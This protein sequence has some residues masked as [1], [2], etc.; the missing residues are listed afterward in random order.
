MIVPLPDRLIT[1]LVSH[2]FLWPA[3]QPCGVAFK[4]LALGPCYYS[5]PAPVAEG[6]TRRTANAMNAPRPLY[7][8]QISASA[9]GLCGASN[10]PAHGGSR[11]ARCMRRVLVLRT[12]HAVN[13]VSESVS[14]HRYRSMQRCT[15]GVVSLG[16]TCLTSVR[17]APNTAPRQTQHSA[18]GGRHLH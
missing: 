15:A 13:L 4:L 14:V 16:R 17:T 8:V 10:T 12:K 5:S 18:R 11:S 6:R 3:A 2:I 7:H 9:C 1:F